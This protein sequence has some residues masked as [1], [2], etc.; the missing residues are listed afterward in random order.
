MCLTNHARMRHGNP[1]QF[2]CTYCEYLTPHKGHWKTHIRSQHE[3]IKEPC[4][5]CGTQFSNRSNVFRHKRKLNCKKAI[6][7]N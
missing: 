6:L 4:S 1:K 5:G 7:S 3:N 2:R